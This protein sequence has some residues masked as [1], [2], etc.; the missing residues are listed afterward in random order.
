MERTFFNQQLYHVIKNSLFSHTSSRFFITLLKFSSLPFYELAINSTLY[1]HYFK[2][3]MT[4]ELSKNV[5]SI[6]N[7]VIFLKIVCFNF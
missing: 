4:V 2:Q 3:K 5:L 6:K 7:V 1:L